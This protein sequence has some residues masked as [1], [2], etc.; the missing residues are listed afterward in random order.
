MMTE[1]FYPELDQG[2]MTALTAIRMNIAED[3]E[4]LANAPYEDRV[5]TQL[6]QLFTKREAGE[7]MSLS[8]DDIA[9]EIEE[10][11]N[12]LKDYANDVKGAD[13]DLKDKA[14]FFRVATALTEK[15]LAQRER[16]VRLKEWRAFVDKIVVL[17]ED[18]EPDLRTRFMDEISEFIQ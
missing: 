2:M 14:A 16:A 17:F 7:A 8:D 6:Q 5:K 11:F 10:L 4:Y 1:R 9:A 12:S 3:P 18:L 15:I 13:T